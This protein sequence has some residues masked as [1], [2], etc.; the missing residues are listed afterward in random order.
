MLQLDIPHLV[1]YSIE[2]G[3]GMIYLLL[4]FYTLRKYRETE[5]VLARF[6]FVAFLV[7]AFSGLYGGIAGILSKTGFEWIPIIGE[8]VVEIYEG[9]ALLS[10][11]FFL[12]GLFRI[13][14]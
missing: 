5:S 14:S 12:I 2:L 8:K 10:L 13:K 3:Y 4:S 11:L 1:E 6:F 9:A 7:L